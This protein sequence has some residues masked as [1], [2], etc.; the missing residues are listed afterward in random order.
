MFIGRLGTYFRFLLWH[1]LVPLLGLLSIWDTSEWSV[2]LFIQ[3]VKRKQR[4]L[5][6]TIFAS[7]LFPSGWMIVS[8]RD[9]DGF[10]FDIVISA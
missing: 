7:S 9:L 3:E 8:L 4:V 5:K 10:D 2:V 1:A 6:L